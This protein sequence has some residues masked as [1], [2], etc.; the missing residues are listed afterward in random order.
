MIKR[1]SMIFTAVI[2]FSAFNLDG[3]AQSPAH[4][5]RSK[6][7]EVIILG[8]IHQAHRKN[9]KYSAEVLRDII[10]RLKPVEILFEMPPTSDGKPTIV[11]DRMAF[12]D[13]DESW[14]A[15][16]AADSLNIPVLAYDQ[17]GRDEIYKKTN[18]FARQESL[19]H[20]MSAYREDIQKNNPTSLDAMVAVDN[21]M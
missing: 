18:Y 6:P 11:H 1:I 15:N 5:A 12:G 16:A 13:K 19:D 9:S 10:I 3:R 20:K 8:T 21:L 17:E 2:L 4:P 7:A 14:A